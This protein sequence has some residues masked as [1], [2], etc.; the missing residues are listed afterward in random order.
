MFYVLSA[1]WGRGPQVRSSGS[2]APKRPQVWSAITNLVIS[3]FRIHGVTSYTA[4]TRELA[5]HRT[6][7]D[8]NRHRARKARCASTF[9]RAGR[10][11]T[12][13]RIAPAII[14]LANKPA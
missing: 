14:T 2:S 4:L 5:R 3:L 9:P 10:A 12:T 11:D 13:T 8:R 6:V 7:I 1:G